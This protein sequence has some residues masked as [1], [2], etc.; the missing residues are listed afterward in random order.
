MD[1]EE[2][3]QM[4][5]FLVDSMIGRAGL[6]KGTTV[7]DNDLINTAFEVGAGVAVGFVSSYAEL[8]EEQNAYIAEKMGEFIQL[9]VERS[10]P[11]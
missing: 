7:V 1:L 10:I 3:A 2:A 6:G 11:Q 9:C 5:S 4:L 8:D